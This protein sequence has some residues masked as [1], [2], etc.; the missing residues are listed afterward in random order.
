MPEPTMVTLWGR[1][2]DV[3]EQE[4]KLTFLLGLAA[5]GRRLT[6]REA[7]MLRVLAKLKRGRDYVSWPVKLREAA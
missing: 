3:S 1:R 4:R 7:Q 5:K 6:P 2:L